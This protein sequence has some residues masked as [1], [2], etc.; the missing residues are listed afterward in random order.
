MTP[1]Q[2]FVTYFSWVICIIVS[3]YGSLI[4]FCGKCTGKVHQREVTTI[5][6]KGYATCIVQGNIAKCL[7]RNNT[8]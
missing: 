3:E 5:F 4:L 6:F 8:D 2:T 1:N 7:F